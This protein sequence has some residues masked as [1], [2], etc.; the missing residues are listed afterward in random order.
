MH[1]RGY[2]SL[3]L[4]AA[5][6]AAI[7]LVPGCSERDET[8]YLPDLDPPLVLSLGEEN[9]TV[10][11]E[12]DENALCVLVYGASSGAHD[13]YGY[14]VDDGGTQHRVDLI[15]IEPGTYF[16]RVI[17][18]DL[19]GNEGSTP[20]TTIVIT[21][22][23]GAETLTY[24]TVDVG[25]GDCHLLEFPNGKNVMVDS[26]NDGGYGGV[27]H[28]AAVDAFLKAKGM[29]APSDIDYMVATHAHRDHYGGFVS[30]VIRYYDTIFMWPENPAQP[31]PYDLIDAVYDHVDS[32]VALVDGMTS[33]AYDF[34]DW[35]PGHDVQV[36]VFSAGAGRYMAP[37]QEGSP[38][39]NDSVVLKVSYG[40]VDIM[41]AADA[42]FF[43]EHRAIKSY[44]RELE[45]EILKVG[46][47]ANDD[48]TSEEWLRYLKARV[49]FISNSLADNDG[50]FDQSV[51]NLLLDH[52]VDYYVTDRAYRNAGRTD[53][54]RPGNLTITTDGE[55]FTVF[56]WRSS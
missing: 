11:W 56:T 39:N 43:V 49:G 27:D 15:D 17:A 38:G 41:L 16:F 29:K 36:R 18:T 22:V 50:V 34:L 28:R 12:T 30:L 6:I 2:L 45:A 48:A 23:P 53:A 3:A 9:G 14:H 1:I 8:A 51:I 35:D 20:E 54:A 21:E 19:A 31:F 26:G 37:G 5:A 7:L 40:D 52:N 33:D 4:P 46:H 32:T 13:H 44:G 47:H 24:T 42:E 10:T 55:T 25:W